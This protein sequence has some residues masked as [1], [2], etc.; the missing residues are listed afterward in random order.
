MVWG[1][2][3]RDHLHNDVPRKRGLH[4]FR[5]IAMHLDGN[6]ARSV[7]EPA[8][9]SLLRQ[10][11]SLSI[12][13]STVASDVSLITRRL[14][15]IRTFL[16]RT[17]GRSS[18]MHRKID[19]PPPPPPPRPPSSSSRPFRLGFARFEEMF[20]KKIIFHATITQTPIELIIKINWNNWNRM[21]LNLEMKRVIEILRNKEELPRESTEKFTNLYLENCRWMLGLE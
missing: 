7:Y 12:R 19:R 18:T 2:A 5:A 4:L 1:E 16:P 13:S 20:T 6:P 17:L 21:G 10:Y 14:Q 9:W 15:T 3:K 11:R 8:D